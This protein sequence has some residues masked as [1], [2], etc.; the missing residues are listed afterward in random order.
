[1]SDSSD[2]Q[3]FICAD[4]GRSFDSEQG[5]HVHQGQKGHEGQKTH[6]DTETAEKDEQETVTVEE[7]Q[8]TQE[9]VNRRQSNGSG[10][11]IH[12]SRK[13]FGALMLIGGI[14]LGAFF[15]MSASYFGNM[16]AQLPGNSPGGNGDNGGGGT[17]GQDVPTEVVDPSVTEFPYDNVEYGMGS[18]QV[19]WDRGTVSVDGRPYLGASDAPVTMVSY[20]DFFCPYCNQHN[21][22]TVPQII[23]NYVASGDVKYYYKHL[24]VVGGTQP[25]IATECAMDVADD[26]ARAF[27][28]FKY[29]HFDNFDTLRPLYSENQSLYDETMVHWAEQIG[30]DANAFEQC[31]SNEETQSRLQTHASEAQDLGAEATPW[32]F[33][34]GESLRGAQQFQA[35]QQVIDGQLNN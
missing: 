7:S 10:V 17:G 21:D 23:D 2:D 34:G 6:D 31:Y 13:Q 20:E 35:F 12:M 14:F 22:E 18:G 25:A 3:E 11:D 24:P 19:E 29:N 16:D 26:P 5:L 32:S 33:V 15:V 4:C 9:P 1:M 27:W 8:G 28:I 30:L